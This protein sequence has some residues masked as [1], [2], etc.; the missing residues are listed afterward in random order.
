MPDQAQ[1][2]LVS[3]MTYYTGDSLYAFF[4]I[5]SDP[6]V[7]YKSGTDEKDEHKNVYTY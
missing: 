2:E 4:H 5:Y 7:V 1:E 3:N 6:T